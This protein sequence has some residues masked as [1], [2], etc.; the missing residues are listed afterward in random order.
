VSDI[1][2]TVNGPLPLPILF[3]ILQ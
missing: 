3:L 1:L 2:L